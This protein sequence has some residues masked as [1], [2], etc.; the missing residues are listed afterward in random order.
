MGRIVSARPTVTLL[1]PTLNE[2]IGFQQILPAIDRTLFD[3]IASRL[4]APIGPD[5]TEPALKRLKFADEGALMVAIARR[6]GARRACQQRTPSL[7]VA[8]NPS[9]SYHC[10]AGRRSR[11][12]VCR[13]ASRTHARTP[14]GPADLGAAQRLPWPPHLVRCR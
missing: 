5:A 13:A 8:G 10:T 6:T 3:D 1:L 12:A 2:G 7:D 14:Y 9:V 4:P 11:R